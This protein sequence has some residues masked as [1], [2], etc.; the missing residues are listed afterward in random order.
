MKT[1]TLVMLISA[2]LAVSLT[3]CTQ[4]AAVT[5]S[6]AEEPPAAAEETDPC[7]ANGHK[8]LENTPNYQ[9]PKT[10]EICGATEGEPL[11]A[12]YKDTEFV[13]ADTEVD[14]KMMLNKE[15]PEKTNVAKVWFDNYKIFDSDENHEAKDGYE[16]RTVDMHIALGD[17][18]EYDKW[19]D[20]YEAN[21]VAEYYQ[22]HE[23]EN[24]MKNITVNYYGE[25]YVCDHVFTVLNEQK[26]VDNPDYKKYGWSGKDTF[27]FD[28]NEAFLV[29]RGF[30]GI[31]VGFY[32][33][34]ALELKNGDFDAIEG[35]VN[36]R[37]D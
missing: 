27:T 8:W 15:D 26:G 31:F 17:D 35:I 20:C 16:W 11:E 7:E 30:D 23:L 32:D 18:R 28:Y 22:D 12:A 25:D 6:R 21:F 5:S 34:T 37:L 36:F 29:P 24:D 2:C 33:G 14:M 10:C 3:A 4:T 19:P 9:Q 13:K 1:K